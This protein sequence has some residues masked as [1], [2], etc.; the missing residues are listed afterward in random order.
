MAPHRRPTRGSVERSTRGH[1]G[2]GAC[3][4]R[5]L[6]QTIDRVAADSYETHYADGTST[7]LTVEITAPA[8]ACS[9][10]KL[11][12]DA[13]FETADGKLSVTVPVFLDPNFAR[14]HANSRSDV[15]WAF[16][17][18]QLAQRELKLQA[19]LASFSHAGLEVW[20]D[21]TPEAAG[22]VKVIGF[23]AGDCLNCNDACSECSSERRTEVLA[24]TIAQ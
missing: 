6:R 15:P 24:V 11:A 23:R 20:F 12:T 2:G 9:T 22:E 19:D 4:R 18:A 21:E 1:R 10:N 7:T 16:P 13:R 14:L 5:S 17:P 3:A 8:V